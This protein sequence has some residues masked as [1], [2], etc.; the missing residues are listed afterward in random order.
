MTDCRVG[1]EG[2]EAVCKMLTVNT[3]LRTL[4]LRGEEESKQ[5]EDD[6]E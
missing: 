2:A 3:T 4:Y 5:S 6:E 1:D